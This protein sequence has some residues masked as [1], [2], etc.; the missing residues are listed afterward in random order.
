M[1]DGKYFIKKLG[2]CVGRFVKFASSM[3]VNERPVDL[4]PGENR[5]TVSAAGR[6]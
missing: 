5:K 4:L 2:N 6:E 3:P 1:N